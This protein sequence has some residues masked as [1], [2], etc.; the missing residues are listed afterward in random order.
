MIGRITS[1]QGTDSLGGAASRKAVSRSSD[2]PRAAEVSLTRGARGEGGDC[3]D[4]SG[5]AQ[6]VQQ[7]PGMPGV[8]KIGLAGNSGRQSADR[9]RGSSLAQDRQQIVDIPGIADVSVSSGTAGG[10][11]GD[12]IWLCLVYYGSQQINR[13]QGR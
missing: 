12:G 1:Q 2:G 6:G 7:Y 11:D 5:L 8:A 10:Q 4:G 13:Y 3:L 9:I